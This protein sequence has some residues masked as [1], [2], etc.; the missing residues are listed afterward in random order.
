MLGP[1]SLTRNRRD[2]TMGNFH[3]EQVYLSLLK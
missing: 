3:S 2:G 1:A